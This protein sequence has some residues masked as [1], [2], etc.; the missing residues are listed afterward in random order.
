MMRSNVLSPANLSTNATWSKGLQTNIVP[1]H[2]PSFDSQSWTPKL[3]HHCGTL[4][5]LTMDPFAAARLWLGGLFIQDP[6]LQW[7]CICQPTHLR[8]PRATH[9]S[10]LIPS[11]TPTFLFLLEEE[12]VRERREK[13][14]NPEV[15]K[16]TGM[17]NGGGMASKD[18]AAA[19]EPLIWIW[20]VLEM[21]NSVIY[22][23]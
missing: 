5:H 8:P 13:T 7:R 1:S 3:R 22:V 21:A 10:R 17:S 16:L 20:R 19:L 6:S 15:L 14:P 4:A 2:T 18:P 11:V 23:Y 12:S 9:C